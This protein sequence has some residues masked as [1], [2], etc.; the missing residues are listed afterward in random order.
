MDL[1]VRKEDIDE[2]GD[3]IGPTATPTATNNNGSFKDS[4]PTLRDEDDSG[5][6]LFFGCSILFL[7][8]SRVFFLFASP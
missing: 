1:Q 5:T 3:Y 8:S 2:N 6:H 7:F 4:T